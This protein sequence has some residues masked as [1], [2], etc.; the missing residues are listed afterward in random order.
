MAAFEDGDGVELQ[1]TDAIDDG[2]HV[3]RRHPSGPGRAE[4]LRRQGDPARECWREL[5]GH[6]ATTVANRSDIAAFSGVTSA[7]RR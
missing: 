4:A 7:P 5:L 6:S 1:G 2:A 3:A